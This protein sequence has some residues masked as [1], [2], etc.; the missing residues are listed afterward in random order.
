MTEPE[1]IN[2][3]VINEGGLDEVIECR[4]GYRLE[5]TL[6]G[7]DGSGV[8][9]PWP[10]TVG[11]NIMQND[12][13]TTCYVTGFTAE[14]GNLYMPLAGGGIPLEY[15]NTLLT[16]NSVIIDPDIFS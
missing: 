6:G 1:V 14:P 5:I 11:Q 3:T 15:N 12:L 8:V 2:T 13:T 4:L 16:A 10:K 9:E 7:I